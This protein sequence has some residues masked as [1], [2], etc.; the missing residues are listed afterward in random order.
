M[1]VLGHP[2]LPVRFDDYVEIV[3]FAA[4]SVRSESVRPIPTDVVERLE[5]YALKSSSFLDT[6]RD[7]PRRFFTMVGHAHRIDTESRRR[8]YKRRPGIGAARRMYRSTG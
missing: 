2:A 4:Q 1:A 8:G 5:R 7:Y 6:L 3:R